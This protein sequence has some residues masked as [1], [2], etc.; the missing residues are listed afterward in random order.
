MICAVSAALSPVLFG[1]TASSSPNVFVSNEKGYFDYVAHLV[2]A[3]A[4]KMPEE[5][6]S[7]KPTPEVR[8]YGQIVAHI[9]DAQRMFCSMIAGQKPSMS[10]S[11]EKTKTSKADL[12]Q[13]LKDSKDS[14]DKAYTGLTDA[15]AAEVL[16][17]EGQKMTKLTTMSI[18]TGHTEE[19]YGNMVTYLRIKGLVPPSSE[20]Q[21]K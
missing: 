3:A 13:A 4:E 20:Q 15:Q 1:Q 9:A 11:T 19:H 7:F 5:N 21:G 12:V 2:I 14:C 17:L 10:E 16:S 8:S 18:N 6:Y